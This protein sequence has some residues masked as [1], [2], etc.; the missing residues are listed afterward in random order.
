MTTD[1]TGR[2]RV[3]VLAGPSGS[4]K[5]RLAERLHDRFGWPIVRLDDFYR[6]LDD[7]EEP[8]MPRQ[9]GLGIVDWD[10]PD[11]W[12]A[13]AAVAALVELV[14]TGSTSTPV[15][16]ISQS[17]AVSTTTV[18]AGPDDL[19]LAEGIFA[20]E[21]VASLREAGILHSAWCISHRPFVTFVR[22]LARDLKERR[23]SPTV[24]MRRGLGLMRA[25]PEVIRRQVALGAVAARAKDVEAQLA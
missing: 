8:P 25:E 7:L 15:Y 20:A 14:D 3:V 5:S 6:N 19:I 10:H 2:A 22:R 13:S 17:R 9:V 1:R 21:I 4:G 18:S 24:L 11:S 12:H 16:D 23:K